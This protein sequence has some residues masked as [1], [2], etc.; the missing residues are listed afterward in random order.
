MT[1]LNFYLIIVITKFISLLPSS[2][3][4][5]PN[6]LLWKLLQT[7]LKKR[8]QIIQANINHCFQE[9]SQE[10]KEKLVDEVWSQTFF[11]LYAN[12]LAWNAS[13]KNISALNIEFL[14]EDI[15][16]NA[17][18]R[19]TGVLLLFRH[20]LYLELSA[21]LLSL[22]YKV[23]GLER[24]NNNR[25]IQMIQRHGRLKSVTS[26]ISNSDIKECV[27]LL[28]SGEVIL[29]G[30]DQDYRNKR[31][32]ISTFFNQDCLTTT[33]PYTLK[34]LTG[35]ELIY[36]D[37]FKEGDKYQIKFDNF[38]EPIN[39]SLEFVNQLNKKIEKSVV[40]APSQYLWHH[41]RFKS[42]APKIY[43]K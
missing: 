33:V 41:R 13:K 17:I 29:Y 2:I 28:K 8:K 7:G 30:P 25:L 9:K 4:K 35:C 10:W 19:K 37:F 16:K 21:R 39:S 22:K 34:K 1:Q 32:V 31:S 36:F 20:T 15:L 6:S 40:Q 14:N 3:F 43:D 27:H 18:S 42:Q 12:N 5:K 38:D 26:L 24:P 23:H 11:A